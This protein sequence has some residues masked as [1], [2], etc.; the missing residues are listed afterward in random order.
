[1]LEV[2]VG[3]RRRAVA[4]DPSSCGDIV[5]LAWSSA[6][7][8]VVALPSPAVVVVSGDRLKHVMLVVFTSSSLVIVMVITLTPHCDITLPWLHLIVIIMPH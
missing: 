6:L 4:I 3:H 2:E 5:I 1:M 8:V 7:V